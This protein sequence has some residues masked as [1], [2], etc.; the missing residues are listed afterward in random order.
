MTL[1]LDSDIDIAFSALIIGA[2]I[3]S[4]IIAAVIHCHIL[5]GYTTRK[6]ANDENI[7][8]FRRL[9]ICSCLSAIVGNIVQIYGIENN[10]VFLTVS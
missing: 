6:E 1:V 5:S 8:L 3:L 2:P 10:S 7:A 9:L 4:A